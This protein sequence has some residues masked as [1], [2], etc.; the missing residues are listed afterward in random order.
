MKRFTN[1]LALAGLLLASA[2]SSSSDK[3]YNGTYT[4]QGVIAD[5]VTG[6]RI[7]GG[8]LQ[9]FLVQG[10][11]VRGPTRLV[12]D[13]NDPLLG[14][15]AFAG[16]PH[17]LW[18][19]DS[20]FKVV[21]IKPGYQRFESEIDFTGYEGEGAEDTIDKFFNRIGNV[22]LFPVGASAPTYTFQV[23][24]NGK[25]VP[26]ATVLLDPITNSN[27]P[28]FAGNY[29]PA[30]T[31]YVQSLQGTT[32]A[33]GK[34][35]FAGTTLALG[36]AYAVEVLPVVFQDSAGTSVQ[37]GAKAAGSLG[38][39]FNDAAQMIS[40]DD[41]VPADASL[42]IASASNRAQGQ[43]TPSGEL[44]ITFNAPV[45]LVNTAAI[46]ASLSV[47]S[48]GVLAT[49]PATASLTA[50]G[51]TLTLAPSWTTAPASTDENQTITYGS[52]SVSP[53]DYPANTAAVFTLKFADNATAVS[54]TVTIAGP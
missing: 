21:V 29:L 8:D 3:W 54:P 15:Y 7:G 12:T 17:S 24:Y 35:T 41:L 5:A 51:L 31:G 9:V 40:L 25:P 27:D 30:T 37:L 19:G 33:D 14:E 39:G 36:G 20:T 22:Y 32:G 47:G 16:I 10:S 4:L 48:T 34:V 11:E 43:I 28:A 13:T 2:C 6:S 45:V 1:G 18:E 44:V 38:V 46:T 50:D 23:V 49:P 52:V 42:Y 53:K 26:N